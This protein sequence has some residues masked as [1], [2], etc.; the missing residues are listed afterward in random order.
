M[1]LGQDV[2]AD[3]A[4]GL[5][6]EWLLTNGLG[7]SASGTALGAHTRRAHGL[8]HAA[9]FH[10]RVST[11]LLKLDERLHVDGGVVELA[12]NIHAGNTLRPAAPCI[13]EFRLDPWPTW[14]LAASGS[15]LEKSVFMISGHHAVAVSYR[16]LGGPPFRLSVSPLLVARA[17]G[18][19]PRASRDPIGSVHGQPGRVRI[20]RAADGTP[21]T[22]WHSGAFLPARVWVRDLEYP[23]DGGERE[24]A[25]VPGHI[26]GTLGG[27]TALHVVAS[28]EET[29]FRTLASEGRL[30]APPP[31]TLADCVAALDRDERE[32]MT[33][34]RRSRIEA[35]DLT[36]R[37]AAAAHAAANHTPRPAP[38]RDDADPWTEPLSRARERAGVGRGH[39]L[40]LVDCY[41]EAAERP[42]DALRAL[43]ALVAL[44]AFEAAHAVLRGFAESI[45]DGLAPHHFDLDDGTPRHGDPEP[46]LWMVHA[47][48]LLG[49][50][51][52][53]AEFLK[54]GMY[55]RLESVMQY[56]RAG[57]RGVRVD[58]DG[59][60]AVGE[61]DAATKPVALN[62]LWYHALVAMAQIARVVGRRESG[63]FYL[64]WAREHHK[65]FNESF[66]DE[67]HG[68]LFE[69]L[70][71]AG[72]EVGLSPGQLL[73]VSLPPAL[74]P[75]ERGQR[76]VEA[77]ERTL[78]THHG[79]RE[80]R[81]SARLLPEWLGAFW[82]AQLRVHGRSP[83]VQA[84]VRDE[85]AEL[86]GALTGVP[87]GALRLRGEPLSLVATAE[88]LRLWIEEVEHA[89]VAIGVV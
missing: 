73:G 38:P 7:G 89:E 80:R 52:G 75:P 45:D 40:T 79:L 51:S 14:V 84:S 85:L 12:A 34:S 11:V 27:G 26:E 50:R 41:P 77:V 61:G 6:E 69:A 74:L 33:T 10:G 49:R 86:R 17:P 8:L 58:S 36:A 64:A 44:R 62:A 35:A 63:A 83:E 18:A 56:L 59:L 30:G 37:Q 39:R 15:R 57:T 46:A 68:C 1:R 60:L 82:T 81:D 28:T 13:E 24:D 72:P 71:A 4:A 65:C 31:R 25:L 78:F 53:D 9:S 3:P 67:S 76:L 29:L 48:E 55:A 43:P 47:A 21:L 87:G 70:S 22:L 42:V 66:W 16:H 88:L 2:L 32:R 19:G 5:A 23:A 20:E 54:E